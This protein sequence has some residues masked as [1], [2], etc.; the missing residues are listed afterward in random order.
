MGLPSA[1]VFR[2][3]KPLIGL[4][5]A[6]A[7]VTTSCSRTVEPRWVESSSAG[8][9]RI[10]DSPRQT[11]VVD[12][13]SS[14]GELT[15]EGVARAATTTAVLAPEAGR[16]ISNVAS[17]GDRVEIGDVIVTILPASDRAS[18]VE[19]EILLLQI[20]LAEERGDT[21]GQVLARAALAT[22]DQGIVDRAAP[23]RATAPGTLLGVT[24]GLTREVAAG[25]EMFSIATSDDLIVVVSTTAEAIRGINAGDRV[26]L[27]ATD[28][29]ARSEPATVSNVERNDQA[30]AM[31]VTPDTPLDVEALGRPFVV[32]I[33]LGQS[34]A[35]ASAVWIDRRAVHRRD[36]DSFLLKEGP[37]GQLERLDVNFG[38]RTETHVEVIDLVV[39]SSIEAGMQLVLP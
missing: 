20:E 34:D 17:S 27:R 12:P 30:V 7:L 38:R 28:I 39:G 10:F 32:E 23:V 3:W 11:I 24:D 29:G 37:S 19:R 18:E 4:L 31:T 21:D 35:G 9:I 26:G 25:E 2:G 14:I 36:G 16:I 8:E 22:F 6:V 1:L 5:L 15:F 13:T 33:D